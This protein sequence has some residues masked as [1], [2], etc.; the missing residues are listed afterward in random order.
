MFLV[1]KKSE[2]LFTEALTSIRKNY[3]QDF[4]DQIVFIINYVI[5]NL[6]KIRFF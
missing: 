2:K 1:T 4:S 6:L 5:Y 3:L